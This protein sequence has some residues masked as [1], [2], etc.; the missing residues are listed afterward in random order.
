[1]FVS[2]LDHHFSQPTVASWIVAYHSALMFKYFSSARCVFKMWAKH[3]FCT[4]ISSRHQYKHVYFVWIS[5]RIKKQLSKDKN[6]RKCFTSK[7][8]LIFCVGA[9]Y[10]HIFFTIC[11]WELWQ[12]LV[13]SSRTDLILYLLQQKNLVQDGA[14]RSL[15]S[16]VVYRSCRENVQERSLYPTFVTG[17]WH[18]S[19]PK[20]NEQIEDTHRTSK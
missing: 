7:F 10:K 15:I 8:A 6:D 5:V 12:H 3:C 13:G 4:E 19:F 14:W 9:R 18:T 11:D 17:H 20:D 16:S 2:K 1:M